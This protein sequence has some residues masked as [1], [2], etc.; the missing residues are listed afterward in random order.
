MAVQA[1]TWLFVLDTRYDVRR[2]YENSRFDGLLL[3]EPILFQRMQR[4][5][6]G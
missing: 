2:S 6:L 5:A 3:R 4:V 1:H